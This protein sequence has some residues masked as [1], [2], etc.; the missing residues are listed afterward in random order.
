M[1]QG[2][3]REPAGSSVVSMGRKGGLRE[4]GGGQLGHNRCKSGLKS[5]AVEG[6]QKGFGERTDTGQRL[7]C[8]TAGSEGRGENGASGNGLGERMRKGLKW[9]HEEGEQGRSV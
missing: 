5:Q 6:S 2:V 9:D 7:P 4:A 8:R 3:K 1:C